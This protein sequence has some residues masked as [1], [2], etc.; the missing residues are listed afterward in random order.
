MPVRLEEK[1]WKEPSSSFQ[2]K[3]RKV[4]TVK[5]MEHQDKYMQGWRQTRCLWCR[6]V[7]RGMGR[8]WAWAGEGI[9]LIELGDWEKL[10][11]LQRWVTSE[12]CCSTDQS[13][14]AQWT[15]ARRAKCSEDR[16]VERESA[17]QMRL[18][19]VGKD[20]VGG[21]WSCLK[22]PWWFSCFVVP[23]VILERDRSW[24]RNLT[25]RVVLGLGI[26]FCCFGFF[27]PVG[28]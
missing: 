9:E 1:W 15:E 5:F 27:L 12:S 13:C 17:E 10:G 23:L 18:C 16:R 22:L 20:G 3:E 19:S 21:G 25:F 7:S 26:S 2:C 11:N 8:C 14:C 4:K 6:L 24:R 28:V